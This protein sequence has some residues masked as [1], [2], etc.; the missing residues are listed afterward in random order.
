M[1]YKRSFVNSKV[2][3]LAYTPEYF[4]YKHSAIIFDAIASGCIL[5]VQEDTWQE[6]QLIKLESAEIS[7]FVHNGTAEDLQEKIILA[8]KEGAIQRHE[9]MLD[10]F[11]TCSPE[12][13]IDY[14]SSKASHGSHV[15]LK[16]NFKIIL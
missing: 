1:S 8:L 4:K 6:L 7:Y 16:S 2:V 10:C 11:N 15:L 13:S 3:A 9:S 5:V 14:L 12:I